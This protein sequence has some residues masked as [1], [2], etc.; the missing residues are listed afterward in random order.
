V[1]SSIELAPGQ[2]EAALV[3]L[4]TDPERMLTAVGL[5]LRAM[6]VGEL[7]LE[8]E[9]ISHGRPD[10]TEGTDLRRAA[11]AWWLDRRLALAPMEDVAERAAMSDPRTA[12][13]ALVAELRRHSDEPLTQATA[14]LLAVCFVARDGLTAA[15]RAAL[16]GAP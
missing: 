13:P 14:I 7:V 3:L 5:H 2:L 6:D 4:G 15:A 16:A 11:A 8:T 9:R 12:L 10:R 1:T